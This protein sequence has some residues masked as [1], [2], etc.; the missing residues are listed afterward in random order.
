MLLKFKIDE[1]TYRCS[2]AVSIILEGVILFI[3]KLF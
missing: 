3:S 2:N 1:I